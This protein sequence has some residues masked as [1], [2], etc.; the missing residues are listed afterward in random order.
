MQASVSELRDD[1]IEVSER[2][3][4]ESGSSDV[5]LN[6]AEYSNLPLNEL[7]VLLENCRKFSIHM[8]EG[9]VIKGGPVP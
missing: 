1:H 6:D 4:S 8:P 5:D 3:N 2:S 9:H 7:I